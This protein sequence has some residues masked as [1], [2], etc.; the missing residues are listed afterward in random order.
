MVGAGNPNFGVGKVRKVGKGLSLMTQTP[1][2]TFPTFLALVP[3]KE[4]AG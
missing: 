1:F 4:A 3:Q 2:L